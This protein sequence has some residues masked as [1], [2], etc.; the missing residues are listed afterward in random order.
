MNNDN[1]D[2]L[3]NGSRIVLCRKDEEGNTI[4]HTFC[5]ENEISRGSSAVAMNAYYVENGT[6][7][8]GTLKEFYPYD[9]SVSSSP[10]FDMERYKSDDKKNN[11]LFSRYGT[12]ETFIDFRN[13]YVKPYE[14]LAR[15]RSS[16]KELNYFFPSYELYNGIP[17]DEQNP[18]NRTVYVWVKNDAAYITYKEALQNCCRNLKEGAADGIECLKIIL[19][20]MYELAISVNYM[21]CN[22]LF[23][24]DLKPENIGVSVLNN[25]VKENVGISLYD[26][27]SLYYDLDRDNIVMSAGTRYFRS[28]EVEKRN[29][30]LFGIGSDIYS[31]GA[32]LY[33]SLVINNRYE[34]VY[35]CE[36]VSEFN[37]DEYNN[38]A[39]NLHSS[40]LIGDSDETQN[41]I[42][43]GM[44][45][46]ILNKSLNLSDYANDFG[47]YDTAF[48]FAADIKKALE[49]LKTIEAPSIVSKNTEYELGVMLEKKEDVYARKN[50]NGATGVIQWLLS[51]CPLYKCC[52]KNEDREDSCNVLVLGAGTFASKFVDTAFELSQIKNCR[53]NITVVSDNAENDKRIYL[54]AR[55]E[56]RNYFTVDGVEP[57]LE[58]VKECPYGSL[59][60]VN[61][62]LPDDLKNIFGENNENNY[63]YCFV[64][65]NDEKRNEEIAKGCRKY[66]GGEQDCTVAFT[67]FKK[68]TEKLPKTK[69]EPNVTLLRLSV[70]DTLESH[71]EYKKLCEMAF[72]AH[73]TWASNYINDIP[74]EEKEFRK[75]YNFYSSLKN[76]L[77]IQYKLHSIGIELNLPDNDNVLSCASEAAEKV[78][79][80]LAELTLYEHR[81]W[82]VEKITDSWRC[83]SD[84]SSLKDDTKDRLH[85]K[86]TCIVP[87]TEK[88]SLSADGWK[89]PYTKWDN[90]S[91]D[92]LQKLDPLDRLS[93]N[94]Y[95]HYREQ[96]KNIS[97]NRGLLNGL[98][99]DVESAIGGDSFGLSIYNDLAESIEKLLTE[100]STDPGLV[101]K[102]N[103]YR[104]LLQKT[105]PESD[106]KG[107]LSESLKKLD[108]LL[109]PAIY[110][111]KH[112][113]LKMNDVDL[114]KNIPFILTYSSSIH[115]CVPFYVEKEFEKNNTLVFEN[116]ASALMLNPRFVT[117]IVDRENIYGKVGVFRKNVK[118]CLRVLENHALQT[119]INIV[120][121]TKSGDAP[122]EENNIENLKKLSPKVKSVSE[123]TYS[124][125]SC[126]EA[127]RQY[128]TENVN[129]IT[130]IEVRDTK[131]GGMFEGFGDILPVY[132]FDSKTQKFMTLP[133]CEFFKY[134]NNHPSLSVGDLFYSGHKNIKT[135][136]PG[137]ADKIEALWKIYSKNK[138]PWKSLTG[139]IKKKYSEIPSL[140]YFRDE[141][142]D[143]DIESYDVYFP[144]FCSDVLNYILK[145]FDNTEY[146]KTKIN[147]HTITRI[148]STTCLLHMQA[149]ENAYE[150]VLK[151][152]DEPIYLAE[153]SL[154]D[155]V[156]LGKNLNI[157]VLPMCIKNIVLSS[158]EKTV[159]EKLENN[160]CVRLIKK[161][162]T[163]KQDASGNKIKEYKIDFRFSSV[164]YLNLLFKEGN[165]LEHYSY[166]KLLSSGIFDDTKNSVT[167]LKDNGSPE[168]EFDL[169]MTKGFRTYVVECKARSEINKDMYNRLRVL[170]LHYGI[171]CES[172]LLTDM[173]DSSIENS[174]NEIDYGKNM[175]GIETFTDVDD[176]IEKNS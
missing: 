59:R 84:I 158:E 167:V 153:R 103:Y 98:K 137:L 48:E 123:I 94:M 91:D 116:V 9:S 150:T 42:L 93:V 99:K 110:A 26:I 5:I 83:L 79:N 155:V 18:D 71:P 164:A 10:S 152:L 169:V 168:C 82:V 109:Y 175:C 69:K 53:L 74:A 31:M 50:K 118:Y 86:H 45:L 72:N 77:S 19:R 81:R 63:T 134:V 130:A 12:L 149:T 145:V 112:T 173:D 140:A 7:I 120:I 102:Y 170:A 4:K 56:M 89:A 66:I 132:S 121:V 144:S 151:L 60:F 68:K 17:Y 90:A 80:N 11:Q 20:C 49:Y 92:E 113:D 131:I 171:N 8:A 146:N 128:L 165:I 143:I 3:K 61:R 141:T 16:A 133:R 161:V 27:N 115:L 142:K 127:L 73:L 37:E 117:F 41:T 14:L 174:K 24:L 52:I 25:T 1:R 6:K 172:T 148:D 39:V 107:R 154:I 34:N 21:H 105:D 108:N 85:R 100:S 40:K 159:I 166:R 147:E 129:G 87:S 30:Y 13:G 104:K 138:T 23:H 122:Y 75:P 76:V 96:A 156:F 95:R 35:F 88:C 119:D 36:G 70:N 28:P 136:E 38:I 44:L 163:E 124:G 51:N 46:N 97:E 160:G 135:S 65:L 58:E 67:A 126:R 157:K 2:A 33:Y 176:F 22:S 64:S 114:V 101:K 55:P 139:K 62:K 32:V 106:G 29:T 43:F 78:D 54:A 57:L 47:S 111:A 125:F 15:Q 162:E